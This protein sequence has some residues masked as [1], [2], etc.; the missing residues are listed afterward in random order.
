L[1]FGNG[2]YDFQYAK[3]VEDTLAGIAVENN[4]TSDLYPLFE[5][6]IPEH[7]RRDKLLKGKSELGSILVE[8]NNAHGDFKFIPFEE[9]F[10][11]KSPIEKRPSW[12][13]IKNKILGEN[14][15]PN[16]LNLPIKISDEILDDVSNK[17][18]SNLSGYQHKIDVDIK[19]D[20]IIESSKNAQYL[21]KPLNRTLINYFQ[22]NEL[23]QK[24]YYPFL[25]LNEHLFMSFAKNELKLDVPMSGILP[26]KKGD[27]HYIVK[28][29]DRFEQFAYGQYD[30]AQLLSIHS[31]D[32]YKTTTEEVLTLFTKKTSNIS[33]REDMLAFQVYSSLI[34][35]SDFHA[36]NMGVMEVGRKKYIGAPLYDVIS[37]GTYNGDAED[38]GLPLSKDKRKTSKYNFED[39]LLI[40][41]FL[42]LPIMRAKEIIKKTIET[43]LDTFPS[44]I[45]KTRYFEKEHELQMQYRRRGTKIF[46]ERLQSLY[47]NKL[48]ELKKLG[49]L[50][51][52]GVIEKYGGILQREQKSLVLQKNKKDDVT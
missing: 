34:K 25:A 3:G 40:S 22:R 27:Y 35:H 36:K 1:I 18:H 6:L 7:Y 44:Y 14:E 12:I 52:L 28:R 26:A 20:E 37:V 33:T 15:Y 29:Y 19:G 17:E 50:Q 47:D 46:S 42:D 8:L 48:I 38:L 49:V 41:K 16:L 10:K 4:T 11:Y 45:Q 43:Y 23:N 21:L 5:N 24:R 31:D 39:M 32:K 51:E 9:L 30:M 2:H 13:E